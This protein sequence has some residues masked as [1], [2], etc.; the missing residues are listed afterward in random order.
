MCTVAVQVHI[1]YSGQ[2]YIRKQNKKA[3][4]NLSALCETDFRIK[5]PFSV[6]IFKVHSGLDSM[7]LDWTDA[8]GP[9]CGLQFSGYQLTSA[10]SVHLFDSL[11]QI[12][13]THTPSKLSSCF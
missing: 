1:K 6:F 9:G 7:M 5:A 8:R 13:R 3:F 2:D 11:T 4:S 12:D 10:N